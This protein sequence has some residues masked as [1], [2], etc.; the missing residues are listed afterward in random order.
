MLT[1][2]K[3]GTRLWPFIV[4]HY[5]YVSY[6]SF[7][8][9]H[10][11]SQ[12]FLF[13]HFNT[14]ASLCWLFLVARSIQW[15]WKFGNYIIECISYS[16]LRFPQRYWWTALDIKC[17]VHTGRLTKLFNL[18]D[19]SPNSSIQKQPFYWNRKAI[20]QSCTCKVSIPYR[21]KVRP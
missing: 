12:Q 19:L 5:Y 4:L 8:S 2:I 15:I 9:G 6:P 14:Y 16:K 18:V 21:N 3:K 17:N 11:S 20:F 1:D 13:I 7:A 10:F